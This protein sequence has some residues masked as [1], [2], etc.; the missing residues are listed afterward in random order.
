MDYQEL[1][2]QLIEQFMHLKKARPNKLLKDSL[3]GEAFLLQHLYRHDHSAL[4]GEISGHMGISSARI[5][6]ALNNL[7]KKGL[8]TRRTDP[9]DRRRV[10]VDLT[11]EGKAQAQCQQRLLLSNVAKML[12]L[13][14]ED[15]AKELVRITS[16][17]A[18]LGEDWN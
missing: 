2:M 12:S 7:E 11:D 17:M 1:A 5:A 3:Q 13:L 10:L 16:K 9:S 15:D 4:P 18:K 6:A 14:G 8:I